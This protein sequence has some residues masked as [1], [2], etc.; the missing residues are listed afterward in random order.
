MLLSARLN[1]TA[2]VLGFDKLTLNTANAS[3]PSVVL[4]LLTLKVG[5]SL[6]APPAPVPSSLIV[7]TPSASVIVP[8]TAPLRFTLKVSLPSKVVSFRIGTV[9]VCVTTPAAKFSVPLAAV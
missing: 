2:V 9:I 1:V 5:V 3:V 8:F 7:P 4:T 6:S